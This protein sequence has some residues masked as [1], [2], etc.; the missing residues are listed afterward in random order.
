MSAAGAGTAFRQR[1]TKVCPS[2][3]TALDVEAV[4]T[5]AKIRRAAKG[6]VAR[7][8]R[9]TSR[10]CMPVDTVAIAHDLGIRVLGSKLKENTLGGLLMRPGD[11]PKIVLNARDGLLRRRLTCALELGHY[12]RMSA[13]TNNYARA[14]LRGEP[15]YSAEEPENVYAR[16]FA[17]CLLMPEEDVKIFAE[18]GM[19]DLEMALQF[20][21]PREAMQLRMK[22]LGLPAPEL[23]VA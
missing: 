15:S 7:L 11:D 22:A 3:K 20:L 17:A 6:D 2:S 4:K 16:E 19:D 18:L 23:E 9:A 14:D 8:L 12:V 21:V 10:V 13:K 5:E 1:E